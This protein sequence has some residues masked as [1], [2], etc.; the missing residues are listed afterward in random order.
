MIQPALLEVVILC[1]IYL[2]QYVFQI[3]QKIYGIYGIIGINESKTLTSPI[4]YECRPIFSDQWWNNDKS[5][6]ECK[7]V[8]YVEKRYIY[9]SKL[10]IFSI[11]NKSIMDNLAIICDEV[12]ESNDDETKSIPT[13]FNEEKT[14]CKM[15]NLHISLACFINY[16]SIND[17]CQ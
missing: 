10:K 16:Y 8:M 9:I 6:C 1:M 17:S 2:I 14:A 13:N 11:I 3:K 5:L 12:I 4:S 7:N 15:Q